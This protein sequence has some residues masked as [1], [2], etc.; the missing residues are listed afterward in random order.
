MEK[1]K[2]ISVVG[3][4]ASGKTSL[5]ISLAKEF[6]GEIISADSRQVYQ[7]LDIG[8]A[9]VTKEEM[10]G[11]PHH[12]IDAVDINTVYSVADFKA[13]ARVAINRISSRGKMPIIA[14]GTFF[15]IDALL[16]KSAVS[17]VP[18]NTELRNELEK[19]NTKSLY[20]ALLKLDPRRAAEIDSD[21]KRRLVRALEIVSEIGAVP[22]KLE[23]PLPY[24]VLT[25][26][27]KVEK[28]LLRER[29]LGR[30][31][32]WLS[33]G[34]KD[35]VKSLLSDGVSRERLQEIGFEYT[36]MLDLI[37]GNLTEDQFIEKFVQK[38]WQ[39]AKRQ[40]TWLKRDDSIKWIGPEEKIKLKHTV[41]D[42][43]A[44]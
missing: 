40:Y 35:E 43:L 44:N 6:N 1:Q 18:P 23:T 34:F 2:L 32:Q 31:K 38:N 10:E 42:F 24:D 8:T 19:K 4:T 36:L 25:L 33:G 26:G 27:I 39:Y 5:A 41:E 21:N 28:R 14:G 7:K 30:A 16:G 37:D 12:L 29:F 9:K 22:E 17:D 15:Y 11:I 13:D 20:T 3:P